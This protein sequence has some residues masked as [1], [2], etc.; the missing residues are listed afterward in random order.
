M[1][2]NLGIMCAQCLEYFTISADSMQRHSQL[3]RPS[4]AS[5]NNDDDWEEEDFEDDDNGDKD[6]ELIFN[7]D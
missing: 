1:H 5:D 2:Y 4:A 7:E 6:N 3:C